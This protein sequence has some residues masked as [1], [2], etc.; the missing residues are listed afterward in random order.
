MSITVS[1]VCKPHFTHWSKVGLLLRWQRAIDMRRP[2]C[3]RGSQNGSENSSPILF[4]EFEN[5]TVI[6]L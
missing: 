5:F 3:G 2:Y 6:L 4:E 1:L